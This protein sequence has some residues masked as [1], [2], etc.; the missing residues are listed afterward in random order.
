MSFD[1]PEAFEEVFWRTFCGND[2]IKGDHLQPHFV[3]AET[4]DYFVAFVAQVLASS[5]PRKTRYLSKNNNNTLRLQTIREAFPNAAIVVPFRD[6]IQQ[7]NSLLKQH[8]LFSERHKGDHFSYDYMRWLG[9]HEF[10][11]THRPFRFRTGESSC[12]SMYDPSNVN[13][14]VN[15]WCA[16]YTYVLE[17]MPEGSVLVCYE[18]LCA[19]PV[20]YIDKILRLAGVE[21][22]AKSISTVIEAARRSEVEGVD[23]ELAAEALSLYERMRD[24]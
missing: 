6:P 24:I 23:Q 18:S 11:L 1:S 7:A 8:H 21:C 17:T 16:T 5:D 19:Q 22:A 14:W 20:A 3:D 15:L 4:I 10:G 9:H 12:N 13:Y 2:Y